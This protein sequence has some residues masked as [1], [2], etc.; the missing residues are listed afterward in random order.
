[1]S[2]QGG[3]ALYKVAIIRQGV[4]RRRALVK[5]AAT[6]ELAAGHLTYNQALAYIR[7]P[8]PLD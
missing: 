1:M 6:E 3:K 7:G 4:R 2:V 8:G 5:I